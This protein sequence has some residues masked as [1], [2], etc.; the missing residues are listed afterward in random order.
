MEVQEVIL[1]AIAKRITWWRAAEIVGISHRHTTLGRALRG[2]WFARLFDRRNK[3]SPK[4][5]IL[6]YQEQYF[7]VGYEEF[8]EKEGVT[9]CETRPILRYN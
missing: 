8:P 9:L 4:P 3:P 7:V 5:D 2:V 6:I 1:R